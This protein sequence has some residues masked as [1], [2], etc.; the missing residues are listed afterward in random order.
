VDVPELLLS[1]PSIRMA[2]ISEQELMFERPTGS[3]NMQYAA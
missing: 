2:D 1:V 3:R